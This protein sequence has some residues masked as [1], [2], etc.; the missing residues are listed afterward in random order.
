MAT[1]LA[2]VTIFVLPEWKTPAAW[3]V[4]IATLALTLIWL[5]TSAL[6]RAVAARKVAE[7]RPQIALPRVITSRSVSSNNSII[8]LLEPNRLFGQS[9]LVSIYYEDERRFEVFVA[10][11]VVINVQTNGYLQIEATDWENSYGQLR[12]ELL[13]RDERALRGLI[14]RPA[15]KAD[16]GPMWGERILREVIS[17]N[18][19]DE[20]NV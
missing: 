9:M 18:S 2:L 3:P 6:S 13:D 14:I 10:S 16:S 11:G 17:S 8:F 20:Q 5:L 19:G 7:S 15:P 1:A 4:A 12:Q